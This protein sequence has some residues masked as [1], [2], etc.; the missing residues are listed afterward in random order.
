MTAGLLLP[1]LRRRCSLRP[2]DLCLTAT[3]RDRFGQR[4]LDRPVLNVDTAVDAVRVDAG[5]LGPLYDQERFAVPGDRLVV[6]GI[7]RLLAP[8][9]PANVPGRV[10]AVVV[11]AVKRVLRRGAPS[12]VGQEC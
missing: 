3:S 8:C 11:D 1:K 12:Y 10:I 4:T 6:A 9:G 5:S 2:T 7:A